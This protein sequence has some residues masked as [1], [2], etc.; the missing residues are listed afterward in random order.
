M[1]RTKDFI[2]EL[3]ASLALEFLAHY[4]YSDLDGDLW[5][6]EELSSLPSVMPG[7]IPD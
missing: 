1:Y 3:R 2:E 7:V 6:V 4:A 5:K